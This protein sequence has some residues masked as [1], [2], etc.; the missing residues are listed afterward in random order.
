[1]PARDSKRM[2][3]FYSKTFGW[4]NQQMG[5]EMGGYVVATTSAMDEKTGFPKQPG[6]I[7]GGF[8]KRREDKD[9]CPSVVIAVQDINASMKKI[10]EGGGKLLD[11]PVEIPG[12]GM[13]ISF[14][15]TEGNRVSILQPAPMKPKA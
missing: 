4:Q 11:K 15:D 5:E 10:E 12:V 3:D 13:Y 14:I 6:S 7:N 1:M 9:D 2:S 8:Y